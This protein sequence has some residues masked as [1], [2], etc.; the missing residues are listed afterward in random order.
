MKV[1]SCLPPAPNWNSSKALGFS[2]STNMLAYASSNNIILFNAETLSFE[3]TF[4]GHTDRVN[5]LTFC[6]TLCA[7]GGADTTVRC[8]D[9]ISRKQLFVISKHK[10]EIYALEW[11]ANK[12]FVISGDKSGDISVWDPSKN[13]SN[14]IYFIQS[15][16]CDIV[17]SPTIEDSL[18]IGFQNGA[19]I[20]VKIDSDLNGKI[21]RRLKGHDMEIQSLSWETPKHHSFVNKY[22]LLASG[23]RD[24]TVHIWNVEEECLEKVINLP[25]P[26]HHLTEQQKSR[27]WVATAWI[28]ETNRVLSSSYMGDL[29][30]WDLDIS[31]TKYQ[32]FVSSHTRS[33]FTIVVYPCGT[34]AVTIS[35]DQKLTL[36]DI[37]QR[38]PIVSIG[39]IPKQVNDIS[40][41]VAD[42]HRLAIACGDNNIR[43]WDISN[44]LNPFSC[45]LYWKGIKNKITYIECHPSKEGLL[46]FGSDLGNIGWYEIYS[47]KSKTFNSYHKGKVSAI[48]WCKPSWIKSEPY[49]EESGDY[50]LIISC[51]S[52]GNILL[53]DITNPKKSSCIN[54]R[55]HEANPEWIKVLRDKSGYLPKKN[56][57]SFHPDGR[58]LVVGNVDGSIEAYDLPSFKIIYHNIDNSIHHALNVL[59]RR[60]DPSALRS[61][62]SLALMLEDPSKDERILRYLEARK[63]RDLTKKQTYE[64]ETNDKL[65]E[66]QIIT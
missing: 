37:I 4:I 31:A 14:K 2:M 39:C 40:I 48:R 10:S 5:A 56:E 1:F 19:I 60:G 28:P 15:P 61:A 32:K 22:T 42:P 18:A 52:D 54:D 7:T 62:A 46:A 64:S 24:K 8:W 55:I 47:D 30:M 3:G 11:L 27:F 6:D 38:K 25:H 43:I 63:E 34:K 21:V 53:N 35:M 12:K 23:S 65:N 9:V 17:A 13:K 29:L 58:F 66:K 16:I 57:I 44:R 45:A 36:W 41:S 20:I 51:G 49:S 59:S 50:C 26:M 33:V